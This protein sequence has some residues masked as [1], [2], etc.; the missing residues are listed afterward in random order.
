MRQHSLYASLRCVVHPA[1]LD[2]PELLALE[3]CLLDGG[4]T[5]L[6]DINA[7]SS[8]A[9]THIVCHP[10]AYQNFMQQRNE[11]FVALVRPEW[12]FRTFLLQRL[13]PVDRFNPNPAFVFSTLAISGGTMG[14]DA[15]KVTNGLITHFGG[16]IVDQKEV[17]PGATHI[18]HQ[19]DSSKDTMEPEEQDF[20]KLLQ[21]TFSKADLARS[22]DAWRLHM[23]THEADSSYTLP[24]CVVAYMGQRAGLDKQHH[25]KYTWIE[26]CV[27][28]QSRVPEGPFAYKPTGA[29][30]IKPGKKGRSWKTQPEVHLEDLNLSKCAQVYQLG[31]TELGTDLSVVRRLSNEKLEAMKKTLH[32]AIVLLAQHIAPLLREKLS[33]MLKTV[34]AKVANV[35]FGDSYQDIVGRVVTNASF[36]VCR[37]RGGFEYNEAMRQGK[38]VVS[39][40]WVLAG[41]SQVSKPTAYNEAIQRPVKSFGSIPGMQSFVITLSGYSSK[42]SPTREE[43]QIAIHATGAC[44]LPVLS[45]AHSTHLLCYEASGEKYKKALSW[46]FD[47]V[48]SH[49]WIFACLSNWDYVPELPFRYNVIKELSGDT[50]STA[51]DHS[52]K[53]K[54]SGDI[55]PEEEIVNKTK[56]AI[57]P[58]VRSAKNA[59][60]GGEGRF[61][62]DGILTEI[63]KVPTPTNQKTP[64][65]RKT[66]TPSTTS[67]SSTTTS[68][69]AKDVTCTL[70]DTPTNTAS[71]S[72]NKRKTRR[73]AAEEESA[74]VEEVEKEP[75]AKT[76]IENAKEPPLVIS[77][78]SDSNVD[79]SATTEAA[80]IQPANQ[81]PEDTKMPA[82]KSKAK[83]RKS[84]ADSDEPDTSKSTR[85][86]SKKQKKEP[87]ATKK[88]RAASPP[89]IK[90]VFL[91]TGD[92]DQA[93]LHTSIITS[94]G[95]SVSE[96]SREFDSNCTH[97]ICSELKRTEKFIAGCAAGKW[98]LKPSY[99]ETCSTAGKFLEEDAHEWG[100][101]KSDKK[102]IDARIWPEV[103]AYWR[104]ER[105]GGHPGAFNGWRFFIHA[106]CVPPRDMCERIVLA[107]GGSVIQLTKSVD[108]DSLSKESTPEAP[109]VA[110]FPPEVPTRD[111]WLKKIK[112]HD[113]ECI[114]A[115]F[116]IDYITKKQSP[117]AKRA[118]YRL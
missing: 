10:K 68:G 116:L 38:K 17:Y 40:Y 41:L 26:E 82:T 58:H 74:D 78:S 93:V 21:L 60:K 111:L 61:D 109:V 9:V 81:E 16:Q 5:I 25:V 32:G 53:K 18:L 34:D 73:N 59:K 105:A 103:C 98:I 99:L 94:L 14:K 50:D 91:L 52:S 35:P 24:S 79:E 76:D 95:G 42:S 87:A 84:A 3:L 44:L 92:R 29:A 71:P 65:N 4:A 12:V 39:I 104:K 70:F 97:I 15:R 13:L 101:H 45:R 88:T 48:L 31:R 66:P 6:E 7:A 112:T 43:L 54:D 28:R 33:D 1:E 56:L 51:S 80:N 85:A 117:P 37:Y 27:M 75:A 83:K 114:K 49:E 69:R 86:S 64:A 23:S 77:I 57:T 90:R 20:Q 2:V 8:S 113:I 36:V 107:G 118:D 89:K 115:T 55:N 19:E 11:R 102:D 46:R 96:F 63:D 72:N 22:V 47:N 30:E 106:K 108:F 67:K 62:V 110:L 100:T